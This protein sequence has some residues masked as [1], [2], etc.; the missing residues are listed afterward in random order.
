V[1]NVSATYNGDGIYIGVGPTTSSLT[2]LAA[3]PSITLVPSPVAPTLGQSITYTAEITGIAG[4]TN[5]VRPAGSVTWTVTGQK[6]LCDSTTGPSASGDGNKALF[7]CVIAATTAGF[8][9]VSATFNGDNNFTALP[10]TIPL[11]ITVAKVS[12]TI[13]LAGAGGSHPGDTAVYTLTVTGSTGANPPTGTITWSVSGTGGASACATSP[14][15]TTLDAVTTYLCNVTEAQYGTYAVSAIYP[16][17][18]NYN[19]MSSNTVTLGV[20]NLTPILTLS[21]PTVPTLGGSSILIATVQGPAGTSTPATSNP[22][23]YFCPVGSALDAIANTC[24]LNS[25]VTPATQNPTT[26]TC[27][28]GTGRLVGSNCLVDLIPT[29]GIMAWTITNPVNVGISCTTITSGIDSSQNPLPTSTYACQ[30]PT[31]TAGSYTAVANFPGD[32]NYTATNSTSL[33]VVVLPATPT[34]TIVGTPLTNVF[35]APVTFTATVIGAAGSVAPTGGISSWHLGGLATGCSP[36]SGISTTGP[37]FNGIAEIYTC[38]VQVTAAGAYSAYATTV[39]D[40][41]YVTAQSSTVS[42]TVGPELTTIGI[43]SSPA[44]PILGDNITFI[45]TI[46][47]IAGGPVPGGTINWSL[48]GTA[49]ATHC[50]ATTGAGTYQQTCTI[51]ARSAGTYSASAAYTGDNNYLPLNLVSGSITIAKSLPIVTV[52]S[53]G[54]PVAGGSVIFN[55]I[56][57]GVANANDPTGA[58]LVGNW[59]MSGTGNVTA[60]TKATPSFT[61]INAL[62]FSCTE[63]TPII[64]TYNANYSYAGDS[65]YLPNTAVAPA[66][67]RITSADAQYLPLTLGQITNFVV[68]SRGSGAVLSGAATWDL[69]IGAGTYIVQYGTSPTTLQSVTCADSALSTCVIPNLVA[70][71]TYYFWV[72][73][74]QLD[75]TGTKIG[76]GIPATFTLTLTAY[77]PPIFPPTPPVPP[78]PAAGGLPAVTIPFPLAASTLTGVGADKQVT[79]SWSTTKDENRKGYLLEYSFD[80]QTWIKASTPDA[81]ATSG[82]VGGLTNGVSTVF[83]LTPI[84]AAGSGVAS[85]VSITPG[86]LAQPPTSLTAQSGDSQ[87]DLSWIAPVDTGGLKINNYVVE[88]ST[89]GTNWTLASSTPGDVTQVNLQGLKNYTNYIFRVSAITNFGRGLPAVLATNTA[90]LPSAPLSL[91]IVTTAS[92]TVTVGWAYPQGAVVGSITGFQVELSLD[93]TV[94]MTTQTVA[95]S[96][97]TAT[98]PALVNG[99]TYEIRVTP[100]STGG[101]GAS[102]VILAA[103][104]AAPDLVPSLKVVS[105][106]KKVTLTFSPPVANGGY[107]VDYYTVSDSTSANGPWTQVISNTGSSLTT[108]NVPNLKNGITYFFRVAAVNQ[109][110]IGPNSSVVSGAPQPSAPA[111]VIKTF[112]LSNPLGSATVTW[113]PAVGSNTNLNLRYLVETSPDGLKWRTATTLPT[114]VRTYTLNLLKGPQLLRI[115][116]VT[117]IGPGIPTLGVR[118]PG[119]TATVATPAPKISTFRAAKPLTTAAP[120]PLT[121]AAPKPKH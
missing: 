43:V 83:R 52:L 5:A 18:A 8:Y 120:K 59:S 72:N 49:G 28:A 93:G 64:G 104:G 60:C 68:S 51:R 55:V 86:V 33:V 7:T 15:P 113:I 35:G 31:A 102:S 19:T 37:I 71:S 17:D 63:L 4:N 14:T 40:T 39:A 78:V 118:I 69:L 77:S 41:N 61:S 95:G 56:V 26:Y 6:S 20:S 45:A 53:S 88:Q 23:T 87:V 109:I 96:A 81:T 3:T 76:Q 12:P 98:L 34:V 100:I 44:A 50:D 92:K 106:D 89:D 103:P 97:L 58:D 27:A 47:R 85:V 121:T 107:S 108:V 91:H 84:G 1:Y 32:I 119:T 38:V 99:T 65:N 10:V 54:T 24:T 25:V 66:V 36:G 57:Q 94:W 67:V 112:I 73:G 79:L 22:T 105:G 9:S 80:G 30:F 42:I 13:V 2:V 82:V 11:L 110:G 101:V 48:T 90:A 75:G 74:Y 117:V 116:A 16:G 46:N 114:S 111:P 115:R 70:G 62:V 29:P 21:S